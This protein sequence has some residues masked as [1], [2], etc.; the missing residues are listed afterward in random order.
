MTPKT[1]TPSAPNGE[2]IPLELRDCT[3]EIVG[4]SPLICH[5]WSEKA[6]RAMLDKQMKKAKQAKEAKRPVVD[7]VESLYWLS[8]KP[9]LALDDDTLLAAIRSG[10]FGMPAVSFKSAAVDACSHIEGV[11]KVQA[12]GAFHIEGDMIAV[13]GVPQ[14]REDMVRVG[15]GTADVRYRAEFREWGARLA[16]RYNARVLSAE[17]IVNLFNVGG[18]AIGIGEWRPE[19][20]GSFGRFAASLG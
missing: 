12:R 9:D 5:A 10:S 16:L 15:M 11:T 3:I 1:K 19:K 13:Q 6:K 18:F 4:T 20:N 14:M 2:A 8:T 17:Q 7:V